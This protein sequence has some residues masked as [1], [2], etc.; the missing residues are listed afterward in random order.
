MTFYIF[1]GHRVCPAD[2]VGLISSLY[3]W[4]EGFGSSPQS[5]CPWVS[6]VVLFPPLDMGCL[7]GFAPEAALED[8]GLPLRGGGAAV[9]V[10]GVLAAPGT[11]G[12]WRLGQQEN[13]A[14]EGYGNQYWPIC[15]SILAWRTPP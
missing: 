2:P 11:Q 1:H 5:H 14:P 13:S 9:W 12:S 15:F 7:L 10:A 4:W 3:S 6:I 8:L